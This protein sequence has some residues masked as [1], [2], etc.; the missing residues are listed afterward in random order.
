MPFLFSST[1]RMPSATEVREFVESRRAILEQARS[2]KL[3]RIQQDI[4]RIANREREF[5]KE[6]L[7]HILPVKITWNEDAIKRIQE[8]VPFHIE[9]IQEEKPE[10]VEGMVIEEEPK[11]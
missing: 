2:G 10:E 11:A 3:R 1:K 5:S 7:E 9:Y 4:K 6:L 8:F